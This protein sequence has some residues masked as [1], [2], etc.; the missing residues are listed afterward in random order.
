MGVISDSNEKMERNKIAYAVLSYGKDASLVS[1]DYTPEKPQEKEAIKTQTLM[2]IIKENRRRRA[3]Y[4][5][6][7]ET[8]LTDYQEYT[9]N[10]ATMPTFDP[11][12]RRYKAL[13][14]TYNALLAELEEKKDD[15]LE[16]ILAKVDSL[17]IAVCPE[18]E[19]L[20][21][22][23]KLVCGRGFVDKWIE[24]QLQNKTD[25]KNKLFE[26]K[27]NLDTKTLTR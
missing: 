8:F 7:I 13:L 21:E 5:Y 25:D 6:R 14:T 1:E 10:K 27:S 17:L 22:A 11:A 9:K 18:Y 15:D 4:C 16:A 23:Y 26:K 20:E 19:H 2:N 3:E 24:A 12:G